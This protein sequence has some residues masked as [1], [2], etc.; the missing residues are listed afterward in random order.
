MMP[1]STLPMG[2]TQEAFDAFMASRDEPG[3]LTDLRHSAWK[4]FSELPMP[5]QRD[6]EWMRTDIR[7]FRLDK[8]GQELRTSLEATSQK[9]TL[10]RLG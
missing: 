9:A 10:G 6:E 4:H 1:E 5:S 7:L 2:F 8:F 3:W